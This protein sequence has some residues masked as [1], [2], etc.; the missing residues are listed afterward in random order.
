MPASPHDVLRQHG[1]HDLA[2]WAEHLGL[3]P[4]YTQVSVYWASVLSAPAMREFAEWP[5][6]GVREFEFEPELPFSDVPAVTVFPFVPAV[7]MDIPAV[8]CL[9]KDKI[10]A[11]PMCTQ[12]R[13]H[14][15]FC[16]FLN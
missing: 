12:T 16:L 13:P 2:D 5:C 9:N 11:P 10:S 6:E 3:A 7:F 8:L 15:R 4:D 1:L 14:G